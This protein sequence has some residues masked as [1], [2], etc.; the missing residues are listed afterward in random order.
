VLAH[1][2]LVVTAL[3]EVPL[4]LEP[5]LLSVALD[6]VDNVSSSPLLVVVSS[7]TLDQSDVV[8]SPD[9]VL[10]LVLV[11]VELVASAGSWPDTSCP[12]T[13][14]QAA[15][16]VAAAPAIAR[17]RMRRLRAR[18]WF[19]RCWARALAAS[20]SI[21]GGVASMSEIYGHAAGDGLGE[22]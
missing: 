15:A 22:V 10:E 17:V 12:K 1:D 6:E 7:L 16:N 13:T 8:P 11:L 3:G 20:R 5:A 4:L 21:G 14:A 2:W 18:C 9:V 19:R